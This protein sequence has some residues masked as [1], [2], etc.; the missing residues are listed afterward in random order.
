MQYSDLCPS[1]WCQFFLVLTNKSA[2]RFFKENCPGLIYF[3]ST[4]NPNNVN[5]TIVD[6]SKSMSRILKHIKIIRLCLRL[7]NDKI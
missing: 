1:E 5:D 3:C 2:G 6:E 7:Y 4:L